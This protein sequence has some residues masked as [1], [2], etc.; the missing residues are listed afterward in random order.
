MSIYSKTDLHVN[1]QSSVEWIK[2]SNGSLVLNKLVQSDV[3]TKHYEIYKWE[4]WPKTKH[5]H[6]LRLIH[7]ERLC[8]G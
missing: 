5:V 2:H 3:E 7:R 6:T 1:R 4:I 8:G